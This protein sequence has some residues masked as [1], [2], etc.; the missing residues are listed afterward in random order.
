MTLNSAPTLRKRVE[1]VWRNVCQPILFW[2]PILSAAGLTYFRNSGQFGRALSAFDM[3]IHVPLDD[4]IGC[5]AFEGSS[6]F[7]VDDR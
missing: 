3:A 5:N 4:A 2:K 6:R 7:G 1:Y